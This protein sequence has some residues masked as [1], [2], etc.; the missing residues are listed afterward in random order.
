MVCI[1]ARILEKQTIRAGYEHPAECVSMP[2]DTSPL[3]TE[4]FMA[5]L[6]AVRGR[7][8]FFNAPQFSKAEFFLYL[9]VINGLVLF[10]NKQKNL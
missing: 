10:T 1:L 5:R 2:R 3:M 9:E 7:L 6:N 8:E 4:P